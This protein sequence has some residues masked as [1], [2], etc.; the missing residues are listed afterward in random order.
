MMSVQTVLASRPSFADRALE[1]LRHWPALEVCDA[2]CSAGAGL[3]V[4]A[5]QIAHLH[6]S[7]EAELRLTWP[8]IERLSAVL[9]DS[10]R[11]LFFVGSDWI[12]LRLESDSDLRLL[13]PL[14]SLAIKVNTRASHQ[15]RTVATASR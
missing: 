3:A 11:V 8:V 15:P 14:V 7:G 2:D 6:R 1:E 12:Q 10:E 5:R 13:L 9:T 4:R